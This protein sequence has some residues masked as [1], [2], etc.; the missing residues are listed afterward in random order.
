MLTVVWINIKSFI[1]YDIDIPEK[2]LCENKGFHAVER[3][4]IRF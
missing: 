4:D 2:C 1:T 3:F